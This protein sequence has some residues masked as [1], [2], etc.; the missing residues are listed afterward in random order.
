MSSQQEKMD[1]NRV[2]FGNKLWMMKNISK[3]C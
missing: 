2:G 1:I 3:I